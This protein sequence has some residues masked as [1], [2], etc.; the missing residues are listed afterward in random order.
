MSDTAY[1]LGEVAR[2]SLDIADINGA[3]VDPGTLLLKV[4]APSGTVVTYTNGSSVELVRDSLG[5]YHT[6]LP[7]N[8]AGQWAYRWELT[9]PN[10]GAAEGVLIV[11]KSRVI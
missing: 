8:A 9:A 4:R 3:A 10:A 7:L 11:Q 1:I 2:I 5:N 6:D